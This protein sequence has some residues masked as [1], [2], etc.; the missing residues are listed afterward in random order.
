[1]VQEE[2]KKKQRAIQVDLMIIGNCEV[3]KTSIVQKHCN[4][5]FNQ[6]VL[7]TVGAASLQTKYTKQEGKMCTVKIWDTA[8]Q[9]RYNALVPTFFR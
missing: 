2:S 7:R 6:K 9:E 8:G 3:G 5:R 4:N 1:M